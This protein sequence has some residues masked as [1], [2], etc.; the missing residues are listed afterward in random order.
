MVQ[1]FQNGFQ[2]RKWNYFFPFQSSDQKT[3][4][5]KV[6]QFG[7]TIQ[8]GFQK[9]EMEFFKQE[10]ELLLPLP[11]PVPVNFCNTFFL[12]WTNDSEIVNVNLKRWINLGKLGLTWVNKVLL[13]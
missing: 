13:G 10:M 7:P 6:S 1:Q 9:Q 3:S 12:I 8:N 2:N 5:T 11:L 4:L